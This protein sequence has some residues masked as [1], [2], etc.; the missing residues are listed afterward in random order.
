MLLVGFAPDPQ[1]N[2]MFGQMP[3]AA[4]GDDIDLAV[5]MLDAPPGR[6]FWGVLPATFSLVFYIASAFGVYR[7]MQP[8]RMQTLCFLM[9]LAGF[10]LSPLG[11][12]GFY[13]AGMSAQTLYRAPP[14]VQALLL[15]QFAA[16]HDMLAV[17]WIAAV[18]FGAAGWL[19][20]AIQTLRGQTRLPRAAVWLNPLPLGTAVASVCSLF[21]HSETA[22]AI[23]GATFNL[24]QGVFFAGALYF[25]RAG[26]K[27]D[28]PKPR[29]A[30]A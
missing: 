5:L 7:L 1:H 20:L 6:L 24:A 10:S 11:H 9:L 15:E 23:G 3:A 14:Q 13:Y 2:R 30:A 26:A 22:A 18:A 27:P 4:L 29:S 25:T 19:L 16:F 17:H 12:A 8:N 21:P 28:A